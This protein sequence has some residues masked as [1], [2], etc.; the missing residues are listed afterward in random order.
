MDRPQILLLGNG[1]NLA[2]GGTSWSELLN[3]IK[4]RDDIP[5]KLHCPMPLQAVLYTNNDIKT[6][7]EN[8][9]QK[10]F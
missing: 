1:L 8:Q 3:K 9:K 7:M 2:Y 6:A 4:V 10:L 5:E